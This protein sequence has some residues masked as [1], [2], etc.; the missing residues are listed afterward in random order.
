MGYGRYHGPGQKCWPW[1][2]PWARHRRGENL[3]RGTTHGH[4]SNPSGSK[5][6]R[7][8]ISGIWAPFG[9]PKGLLQSLHP[10]LSACE[11]GAT[12]EHIKFV[13]SVYRAARRSALVWAFGGQL[14]WYWA[15]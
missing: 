2:L 15:C 7:G 13:L 9:L 11:V 12:S 5:D 10:G 3:A 8:F 6:Q 4:P 1:Y 14:G